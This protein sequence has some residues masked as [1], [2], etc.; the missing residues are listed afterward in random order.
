MKILTLQIEVFVNESIGNFTYND[1]PPDLKGREPDVDQFI[2]FIKLDISL[3][4]QETYGSVVLD[5]AIESIQN[6]DSKES[7]QKLLNA[8][9]IGWINQ[10][11]SSK[12]DG[13][14]RPPSTEATA[15]WARS[16]KKYLEKTRGRKFSREVQ[17]DLMPGFMTKV[18]SLHYR[19]SLWV[20]LLQWSAIGPTTGAE[21]DAAINFEEYPLLLPII[22][23]LGL[24]TVM[25]T[26]AGVD[27]TAGDGIR[28]PMSTAGQRIAARR[29]S[30]TGG[31][32]LGY[33]EIMSARGYSRDSWQFNLAQNIGMLMDIYNGEKFVGRAIQ[34]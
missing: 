14:Y 27:L 1:L 8:M 11:K 10:L 22:E 31:F 34:S 24:P 26:P 28:N 23:K 3:G 6:E 20:E 12:E 13:I 30:G 5:A 29:K 33:E 32:Q 15:K 21:Q 4:G 2:E 17:R 25:G 7:I 9:P 16:T 18:S 19:P